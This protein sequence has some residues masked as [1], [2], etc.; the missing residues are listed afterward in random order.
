MFVVDDRIP[1]IIVGVL[2]SIV[3]ALIS[4]YMAYKTGM[5]DGIIF[6]LLFLSYFVFLAAGAVKSRAFVY[7]L[8]IMM[9]STAAVIAYTDGLG[10]III[11]GEPFVL[12][13]Y[14][15]MALLGMSGIIGMLM[16]VYFEGYFLKGGFPWP[17][18]RVSASIIRLLAAE[19]RDLQFRVSTMRMATAGAL[20]GGIALIRGLGAIPETVGL[21]V[22]GVSV[23]PMMIGIGMLIGV[24]ACL[25]IALGAAASLAVL[26]FVEGAAVDYTTHMKNPWVFST[27]VSMMVTTAVITL[28]VI[29]KPALRE[30]W[31][32]LRKKTAKVPAVARDGGHE[33]RR[34]P[35]AQDLLLLALI[36]V[37]A[38]MMQA[39]AGVPA[40]IFLVCVPIALLFQVIE[41]RGRAEMSM[42]VGIS[43]FIVILLVGLAFSDIVPLLI[44]EGFVVAM[45]MG[46]SLALTASMTAEYSNVSRKGLIGAMAIGSIAG[47]IC[48]IPIIRFLDG[49]YGIGTSALPAP[50]SVMWL[51]M[52]TTAVNRVPSPSISIPLVLAGI[53]IALVL[54]RYKISA[55]SVA[56]GLI[57]PVS[58][59]AA[60]LV[61]GVIA[62]YIAKKGYLKNDNGI[63]ASGLIAGDIVVGLALS[64]RTLL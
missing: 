30:Q 55:V 4:V 36:V 18:S 24:N 21:T 37:A 52:A 7:V 46:F 19:K 10:A 34:K 53:V 57:L 9:S 39:F 3:N 40:W 13:D 63:T 49:L 16:A 31:G 64:L 5:A 54:Y 8:A 11:S 25:Q 29:L 1:A 20:S 43:S 47:G 44:L 48:C 26:F 59:C 32:R 41:T 28:Y 14:A 27:A 51:E 62:W 35:R 60:L 50:Y 33:K 15:M 2:F 17:G 23:S 45:V 56:L 6:L 12:S 61:G 38:V 58:L 22:A 42:G